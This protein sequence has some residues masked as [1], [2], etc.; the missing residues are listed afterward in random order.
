MT[1]YPLL[2]ETSLTT[3]WAITNHADY[4][5]YELLGWVISPNSILPTLGL[6]YSTS[7]GG[8][9]LLLL[10]SGSSLALLQ[11]ALWHLDCWDPHFACVDGIHNP[12]PS[13]A[14]M[15]LSQTL[16]PSRY[17][18][19]TLWAWQWVQASGL[20]VIGTQE[21]E[22]N[23]ALFDT[24]ENAFLMILRNT[25]LF[26]C[27][28]RDPHRLFSL[29]SFYQAS[30][31]ITV[32][33]WREGG[34]YSWSHIPEISGYQLSLQILISVFLRFLPLVYNRNILIIIPIILILD[35]RQSVAYS[36]RY[37]CFVFSKYLL[38]LFMLAPTYLKGTIT[39][40]Q[41]DFCHRKSS[42]NQTQ[43]VR[44]ELNR[45]RICV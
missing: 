15:H 27:P 43:R 8:Q 38:L 11:A 14:L 30:V 41:S 17:L 2:T 13:A 1:N 31:K 39:K 40:R 28:Q 33:E 26:L 36:A 23:S 21:D 9:T 4:L 45:L 19:L 16:E 42:Y 29:S 35:Q 44:V 6:D 25:C 7:P 20:D 32:C 12:S 10:S 3:D 37:F 18:H 34:V 5:G 22:S 24:H